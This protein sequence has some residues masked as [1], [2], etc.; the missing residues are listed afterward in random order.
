ME[1][2]NLLGADQEVK[3]PAAPTPADQA[4]ELE[5]LLDPTINQ[6]SSPVK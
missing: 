3:A 5:A 1:N 2:K 6:G 4:R